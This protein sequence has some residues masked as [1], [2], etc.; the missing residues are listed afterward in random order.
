MDATQIGTSIGAVLM[1]IWGAIQTHKATKAE[2]KVNETV[3]VA[4]EAKRLLA[5]VSTDDLA[6][7]NE[8][9]AH[10]YKDKA[11]EWKMAWEKEHS[12]GKAYQQRV[13]DQREVA[14]AEHL[15]LIEENAA[16]RAR[17]D[18]TPIIK[19]IE[20][21]QSTMEK[22]A[23]ALTSLTSSISDFMKQLKQTER[24]REDET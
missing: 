9:L 7:R 20:N 1:A 2:K 13:H 11:E 23:I 19:Y 22:V 14:N 8:E 24:L 3:A 10:A 17:T 16:L 18:L 4:D 6:K 15:K 5:H 21:G 12:E